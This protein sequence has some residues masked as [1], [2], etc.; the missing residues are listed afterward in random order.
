[1]GAVQHTE[2][3]LIEVAIGEAK[4]EHLYRALVWRIPRLPEK[5]HAAYKSHQ[6]KFFV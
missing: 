3:T 1:M 4:Y 5:H 2:Q 6:L